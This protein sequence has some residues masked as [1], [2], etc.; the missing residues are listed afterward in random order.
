MIDIDS[1]LMATAA[2]RTKFFRGL[3]LRGHNILP[4][5]VKRPKHQPVALGK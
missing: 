4:F 5:L 1:V 3:L 2:A